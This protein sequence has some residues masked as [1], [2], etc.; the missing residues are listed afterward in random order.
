MKYYI[1]A[2]EPSG[3]I[4]GSRLIKEI[5]RQN[6]KAKIRCWGGDLMK[7]SGGE[8]AMHYKDLAFMG[9]FEVLKNIAKI[10]K[11]IR[12]CKKDL[13]DFKPDKLIFIDYPGFNL[14]IAKWAKKKG[15]S[16]YFYISPQI[17]A[18]KENR[19]KSIKR[20]IDQ[21]YVILPFEKELYEKKHKYNVQYFGHPLVNIIDESLKSLN[22]KNNLPP[23]I[24]ILPGSRKQEINLILD[25]ILDVVNDFDDYEFVIAGLSHIKKETYFK[26]IKKKNLNVKVVFNQTYQLLNNSQAAIVTSG[27]ATL[28][29]ALIGTPQLVCYATNS[30]NIFIARLFVRV[31]FISLVNLILNKETVRE[32]VQSDVNSKNIKTELTQ[33]LSH[34]ETK[35]KKDYKTIRK[36]LKGK[37]IENKIIDHINNN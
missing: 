31:N 1:I 13:L 6:P 26:A 21:M 34:K 37:N 28:E 20:Y 15:F 14:R 10:L 25:K 4:Y 5:L 30:F 22:R 29:T 36:L 27:T 17:W 8:L 18:W 33:I 24:A 16:T 35:M 19:V 3:D 2:G 9:F 7:D 11:N 12:F 32:L 23:T